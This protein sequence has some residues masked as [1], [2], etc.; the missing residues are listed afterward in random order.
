MR[1]ARSPPTWS[2]A[3]APVEV[4]DWAP[5]E[6]AVP[7]ERV[8]AV[9]PIVG[10]GPVDPPVVVVAPVDVAAAEPVLVWMVTTSLAVAVVA[11]VGLTIGVPPTPGP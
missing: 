7:V 9:P 6:A 3:P 1:P 11:V 5:V 10:R 2:L 4:V 8:V